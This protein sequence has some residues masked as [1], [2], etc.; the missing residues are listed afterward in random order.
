MESV[1]DTGPAA[2]TAEPTNDQLN[3]VDFYRNAT[4]LITGGTGFIGKV[5]VEKLLRCFEVKKIFLLIRRK[6]SASPAE[7]LQRMFEGPI[8]DTIR[9]TKCDAAVKELFAKVV[10]VEASF[11]QPDIVH[12]IDRIKLCNEVQVIF[13]VMAS[14]RFDEVLDDAIAMNVTSAQRLYA[15]A[16]AMESLRSIVHVSTFY[17][18][19]NREH[20]E[21]RIYDD[22]PFGGVDNIRDFF[23]GLDENEKTRLSR[24]IIGDMPNSYV[25]SKKCAEVMV[26][27]E[28]SELPIGI[29]RPPIVI[30]GYRE[31]VPGWVDCFHGAT[32]L[33]VPMV[34]GMTWWYYGKPEMKTLMSPVDHTVAGM[35][36]TACDIYRRQSSTLQPTES[37][38]VYNFTFEKNAF[39]Y[40]D[41]IRLVSLGF[42][43]PLDRWM[44]RIKNRIAPWKIFTKLLVWLMM[45]QARVT[46]GILAWFGKRKSNVRIV[47]AISSLSDAVEY[48]RCH[49][50][51]SDNGN[52][53]RMLS[54]LS[55]D[56]A[57][58]L[59]FDGD[60]IDWQDYH[61][62]FADGITQELVRKN[63]S[64]RQQ[65]QMKKKVGL[66]QTKLCDC[67]EGIESVATMPAVN[68]SHVPFEQKTRL[69]DV[70]EFYRDAVVL[71]TGGTGFIGKV[72]VEKL[73]RSLN[74]K[75]IYLLIRE[76]RNVSTAERMKEMLEDPIFDTI[77]GTVVKPTALLNKL[78][79]VEVDFTSQEFVKEPF[80][81]DLLNETQIVFHLMANVRFDLGLQNV[82]E[83]NVT[84][85]ERLYSFIRNGSRLKSI[86]HV[87]SFFSNCDRSHVDEYIYDDIPF[88]GL[89]N[90][91]T[92]WEHLSESE[93]EALTPKI[94]G[95]MPN[96]YVFSKKC[97]EVMIS[98]RFSDLPV[99]IFRPP[100][101]VPSYKEPVPG[102]IDGLQGVTGLCVPILKHMLIWYYGNPDAGTPWVPVDYCAAGLIVSACDTYERHQQGKV[103][104]SFDRM[105]PP[106][107]VYNYCF[108]QQLQ[109]WQ[110]FSSYVGLALPSFIPRKLSQ[111]RT[112]ITRW[113]IISRITFALLYIQAYLSDAVL[114]VLGKPQRNMKIA[115][116]LN[117][118]ANATEFFRCYVWTMRNDNVKRMRSLLTEADASILEFDVDR[119][120]HKEYYRAYVAGLSKELKRREQRARNRK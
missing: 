74:V 75:R 69:L 86:V 65:R 46:D 37:V 5:L 89:D 3:V 110:E 59:D 63:A 60:R 22:V 77:R 70:S 79:A 55:P 14:I 6:G 100:I 102:W 31:P 38:P 24:V 83:T 26:G 67:F 11:E 7:R 18:N 61:K 52:V 27:R 106:P 119:I 19:C 15:L 20:I 101:V 8:F 114:K 113:R 23:R 9:S 72:L 58:L 25:F 116:M 120:D 30:S 98:Q 44:S 51:S 94:I 95:Q 48:F 36:A 115:G 12:Q 21:E 66:F 111:V 28:F 84:N 40:G 34:L 90:I 105:P 87:S 33:C 88:G 16:R 4:V 81:T 29:F 42:K 49:M 35:I 109:T 99:S 62:Y 41:Y 82:I 91:K 78:V 97:A 45:L 56:D 32:G 112:R 103:M 57:R 117:T 85:T 96:C 71:V 17:S 104:A 73:L 107:P 64:R 47:S 1:V 13:H 68:V 76:K 80:K 54:M 53:T 2:A 39:A 50:W 118:L 92:I 10:A 43:N 93:R 108:D